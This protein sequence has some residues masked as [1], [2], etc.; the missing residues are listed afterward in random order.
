[1]FKASKGDL[2][3]EPLDLLVRFIVRLVGK[4][5]EA[6]IVNDSVTHWSFA[7]WLIFF[8]FVAA[9]LVALVIAIRS[10]NKRRP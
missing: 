4:G 2:I 6:A 7:G 9:C 5:V 8:I 3:F 1:M 10:K